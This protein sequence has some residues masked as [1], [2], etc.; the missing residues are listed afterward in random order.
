MK[1]KN[2]ESEIHNIEDSINQTFFNS[3]KL[4]EKTKESEVNKKSNEHLLKAFDKI[5]ESLK[6]Y[7]NPGMQK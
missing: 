7:E 2:R 3:T 6:V 1:I 5:K 4:I